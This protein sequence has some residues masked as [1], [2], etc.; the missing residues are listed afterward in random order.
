MKWKDATLIEVLNHAIGR[1]IDKTNSSRYSDDQLTYFTDGT[2][3]RVEAGM[4]SSG[5]CETCWSEEACLT[6]RMLV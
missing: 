4:T 2:A 1:E 6:I 5:Y 3:V